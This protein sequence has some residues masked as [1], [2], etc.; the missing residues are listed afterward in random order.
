MLKCASTAALHWPDQTNFLANNDRGSRDADYNFDAPE[1]IDEAALLASVDTLRRGIAAD[2][3]VYDFATHARST[4]ASRRVEPAQARRYALA[5]RAPALWAA[6]F[7]CRLAPFKL[8][9]VVDSRMVSCINLLLLLLLF[10]GRTQQRGNTVAG[11]YGACS[12]LLCAMHA[13]A[14]SP[15]FLGAGRSLIRVPALHALLAGRIS[16]CVNH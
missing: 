13:L 3:P 10:L 7:V 4:T 9:N 1:A 2:I 11:D 12:T 8:A 5:N 15:H 16:L 6:A 14:T